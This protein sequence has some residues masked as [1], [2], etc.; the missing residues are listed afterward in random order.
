MRGIID[1]IRHLYLYMNSMFFQGL[2]LKNNFN[3][4]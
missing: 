3:Y 4:E 1:E 2:K